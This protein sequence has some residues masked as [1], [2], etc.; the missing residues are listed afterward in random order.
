MKEDELNIKTELQITDARTKVLEELE[1]SELHDQ[2]LENSHCNENLEKS[3][4]FKCDHLKTSLGKNLS[5]NL[6]DRPM[7]SVN[8]AL[9]THIRKSNSEIQT[10]ARE[11]NKPKAEIQKFDGNPMEYIRFL[12]QF[13]SGIC[14]NTESY[15]E[16][17]NIRLEKRTKL[18]LVFHI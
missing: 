13:N 12:R 17:L 18:H 6:A 9:P 7:G 10:V 4:D 11:L 5:Q 8:T 1:R 3:V 2:Q 14:A 15:E 16:R